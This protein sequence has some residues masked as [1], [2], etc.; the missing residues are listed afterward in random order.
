[1]SRIFF[2]QKPAVATQLVKAE[3]TVG[4]RIARPAAPRIVAATERGAVPQWHG[5]FNRLVEAIR[6]G[7]LPR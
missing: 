1:M 2:F 3:L 6:T 7:V 5:A 4:S